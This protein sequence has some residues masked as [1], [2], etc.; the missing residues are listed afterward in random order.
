M[1]YS[2]CGYIENG[3]AYLMLYRNR[4]RN[5]VNHGKWIGVGGKF[6]HGET[7]RQCMCREIKEETG[8]IFREKELCFRGILY[9]YYAEKEAEKIWIYTVHS[10]I[11]DVIDCDEGTLAWISYETILD[12]PLW[13]GDRTF[14][15]KMLQDDKA[16][17][18]LDLHYDDHG[19]LLHYEERTA[20]DE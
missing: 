3:N 2:T 9:F 7:A 6:E 14:L 20:E 18:V 4:K 16:T 19:N 10:K 8:L 15:I 17:F 13:E 11:R 12:L 5:D 1:K